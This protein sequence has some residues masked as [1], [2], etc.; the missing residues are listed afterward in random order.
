ME[1]QSAVDIFTGMIVFFYWGLCYVIVK[2][3]IWIFNDFRG[4]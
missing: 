2:I 4:N 3:I 1:L